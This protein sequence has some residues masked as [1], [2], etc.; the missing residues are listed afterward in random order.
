M[1]HRVKSLTVKRNLMYATA[2]I[3]RELLHDKQ[4][5]DHHRFMMHKAAESLEEI[6]NDLRTEQTQQ[7]LELI[8]KAH[9]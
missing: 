4:L 7:T 1:K 9:A 3:L 5:S 6:A 2:D 8:A